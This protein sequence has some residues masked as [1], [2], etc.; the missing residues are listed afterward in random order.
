MISDGDGKYVIKESLREKS[1]KSKT[2]LPY[3]KI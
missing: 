3:I 1:I 2:I